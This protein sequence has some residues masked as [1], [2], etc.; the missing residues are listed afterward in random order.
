MHRKLAHEINSKPLVFFN[1]NGSD[2][3]YFKLNSLR[4]VSQLPENLHLLTLMRDNDENDKNVLIVRIEHF[5]EIGEDSILSL[6][7][8][9]DLK[10]FLNDFVILGVEELALGANIPVS[11]L[12]QRLEW[13][14]ETKDDHFTKFDYFKFKNKLRSENSYGGYSYDFKPMQIRT[15]RVWI[16]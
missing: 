15:F 16:K 8:S 3:K 13:N 2:S 9:L 6:P 10:S 7:V 11:E 4:G 12:S 5:Y 14:A 1:P